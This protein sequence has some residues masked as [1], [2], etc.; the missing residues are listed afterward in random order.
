MIH[1]IRFDFGKLVFDQVMDLGTIQHKDSRWFVFPRIIFSLFM[2]QRE[3]KMFNEE[4]VIAP[5][6]Y[7]KDART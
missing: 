4:K 5:R 3:Q 6:Y 1:G 2:H 7:K